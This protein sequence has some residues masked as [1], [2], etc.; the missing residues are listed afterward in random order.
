[1]VRSVVKLPALED[2]GVLIA[3]GRQYAAIVMGEDL[4]LGFV[5]PTVDALEFSISESLALLVR[6]PRAIRV[7]G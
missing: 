5:G 6:E 7:L 1:M 3:E 4:S 2:G